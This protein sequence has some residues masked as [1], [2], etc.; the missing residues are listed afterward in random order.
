MLEY[1]LGPE[2]TNYTLTAE[3]MEQ[4]H[5][6]M[7]RVVAVNSVAESEP[8]TVSGGFPIGKNNLNK[9]MIKQCYSHGMYYLAICL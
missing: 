7:I 5:L 8:G 9:R 3:K 2:E 4:C 1:I 6:L